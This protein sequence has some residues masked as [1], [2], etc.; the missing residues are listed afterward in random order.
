MSLFRSLCVKKSSP[1]AK[2]KV[3]LA[4]QMV[5]T[6]SLIEQKITTF[7]MLYFFSSTTYLKNE[8]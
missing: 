7:L 3:E 1:L 2:A 4:Y 8:K 6:F 5:G